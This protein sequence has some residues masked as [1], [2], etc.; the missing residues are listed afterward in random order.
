MRTLVEAEL[1][2]MQLLE[3]TEPAQCK[4]A[5]DGSW[6]PP[7]GSTPGRDSCALAG[8]SCA[9]IPS[10]ALQALRPCH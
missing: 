7:Q 9:C 2:I 5:A 6:L 10:T 3:A 8:P 1:A 4:R